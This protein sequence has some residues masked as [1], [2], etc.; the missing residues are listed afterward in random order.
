MIRERHTTPELQAEHF[1]LAVRRGGRQE[2]AAALRHFQE[3]DMKHACLT[4]VAA[5]LV[6]M[7]GSIPGVACRC[8]G[9]ANVK[10]AFAEADLVVFGDVEEIEGD[11]QTSKGQSVLFRAQ[12]SWKHPAEIQLRLSNK[13][14]CAADLE[15]GKTYLLFL[16][17]HPDTPGFF[18]NKCFGN[19]SGEAAIDAVKTFRPGTPVGN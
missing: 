16:K 6:L 17:K 19:L 9:P 13:T 10:V 14:T 5:A 15:V 8:E 2:P 11:L 7:A 4:L 3:T 18:A 12:Q 1:A